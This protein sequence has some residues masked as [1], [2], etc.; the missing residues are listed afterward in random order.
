[1]GAEVVVVTAMPRPPSMTGPSPR[2]RR[3]QVRL[4]GDEGSAAVDPHVAALE[5]AGEVDRLAG[6]AG[7]LGGDPVGPLDRPHL[8]AA[9]DDEPGKGEQPHH[10][11][12]H[13]QGDRAAS[14]GSP[15]G[16]R[17]RTAAAGPGLMIGPGTGRSGW[18][19]AP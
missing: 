7:G 14:D 16:S 15:D 18:S 17:D 10:G 2:P 5:D 19:S 8:G 1:M 3:L 13:E 12:R 4:R 11:D 9:V 6:R